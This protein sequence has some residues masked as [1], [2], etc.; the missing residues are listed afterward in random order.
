MAEFELRPKALSDLETIWGYTVDTWDHQQAD[1][2]MRTIDE[3][4]KTLADNAELGR[5]YDEVYK[6][7][8]VY[9]SGKHLVFYFA[10]DEG[11]DVVRVLH[12]R[13]DIRAQL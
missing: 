13:M 6:G 10:T 7:L 1:T 3:T 5:L 9:P 12:E 4:F 2:Y 11:I 8:R